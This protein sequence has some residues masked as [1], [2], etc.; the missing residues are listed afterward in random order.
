[1]LTTSPPQ[2]LSDTWKR[3]SPSIKATF[4]SSL[5][6]GLVVHLFVFTNH[7]PNHDGIHYLV[8]NIDGADSGRWFSFFPALLSSPFSLPWVNGLLSILYLSFAACLVVSLLKIQEPLYCVLIAALMVSFPSTTSIFCFLHSADVNFFGLLLAC[9]AAYLAYRFK[10]G[11]IA[12]VFTLALS[13]GIYQTWLGLCAGLLLLALV[14]DALL[15]DEPIKKLLI[16]GFKYLGV[17]L[18]GVVVYLLIMR[19]SRPDGLIAYMGLDNMGQI[20][21]VDIPSL[22]YKA[23]GSMLKY[24]FLDTW[25]LHYSFMAVLFGLLAITG[26]FLLVLLCKQRGLAK[27]PGKLVLL[28]FL[29]ALF[30]LGCNIIYVLSPDYVHTL[31]VYPTVLVLMLPLVLV[32]HKQSLAQQP[33]DEGSLITHGNTA[34]ARLPALEILASWF[35]VGIVVVTVFNYGIVANKSYFKLNIGYEQAYAQSIGLTTQ[36]KSLEGYTRDTHVVLVGRYNH[37]IANYQPSLPEIE[38]FGPTGTLSGDNLIADFSF[39]SFLTKYL[40]FPNPITYHFDAVVSS[41]DI[42]AQLK[43]LPLYPSQGS[44][45]FIN[46]V[47]YVNLSYPAE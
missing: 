35:I 14:I 46:D 18:A 31:M 42:A 32:S 16:R 29:L 3:I 39:H 6:L 1:M 5:I 8:S 10:Y 37:G 43:E 19:M 20:P 44:V 47:I 34:L 21:L 2:F 22:I 45:L 40:G 28:I 36:I 38:S 4:F 17:L 11:A 27:Q 13:L 15:K 12:A 33:K 26:C 23:Y 7:L 25:G 24:F 9:L 41:K 30:P